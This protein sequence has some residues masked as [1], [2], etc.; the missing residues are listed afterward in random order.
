S[1]ASNFVYYSMSE[2][3]G[4]SALYQ[5]PAWGGPSRKLIADAE[6]NVTFSPD[7]KTVA[8]IRGSTYV[9]LADAA[10]GGNVREL[11]TAPDGN[12]YINLAWSS[13]GDVIAAVSFSQTDG[14]DHLSQ[15]SV[16]DGREGP[17][18]SAP[19]LRLRGVSWLSD[20]SGLVVSGR[21]REIQA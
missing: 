12:R 21:D 6:K 19:W 7:G 1:P 20:G 13:K 10:D 5:A 8:F 11:S 18:A 4:Q 9:M 16:A 14:Y 3:G 17:I 15:I 2:R